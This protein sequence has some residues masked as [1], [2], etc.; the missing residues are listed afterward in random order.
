MVRFLRV[1]TGYTNTRYTYNCPCT[2]STIEDP[3]P[4]F[5]TVLHNNI[6]FSTVSNTFSLL[7]EYISQHYPILIQYSPPHPCGVIEGGWLG[8]SMSVWRTT[9]QRHCLCSQCALN[10][11]V[12]YSREN[13]AA[14]LS[15]ATEYLGFRYFCTV[16]Y[17]PNC[18]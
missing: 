14:A 18:H 2:V 12:L 3:V 5:C 11:T 16:Q 1:Y 17:S 9:V 4:A 15:V 7:F 10:I 6:E 13:R 8:C